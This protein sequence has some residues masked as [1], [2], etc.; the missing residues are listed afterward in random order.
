M[1]FGS[2]VSI[3]G[4]IDKA[5]ERAHSLGCECFQIFSRSPRGGKPPELTKELVDSFLSSRSKY[6]LTDYYIHTPYYINFA[7]AKKELRESASRIIREEL[8]RASI[9]G[10][11]YIMTHLGSSKDV[12]RKEA[13][14]MV[15]DGISK[16]IDGSELSS[17]LLLENTAG[18]GATIG[19]NFE[20]LAEILELVGD[21]DIGICIDTAHL[22][23]SGYDIRD[24]KALKQT[25]NI[26]SKTTGLNRVK[27]IHGNDSKADIGERK[28]RHEHIGKG[29]IGIDGFKAVLSSPELQNLNMIAELPPDKVASDITLLK[30]LREELT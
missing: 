28:D 14:R 29:K 10:A 9:I 17:L 1:K 15:A 5:P 21:P 23:A 16:A 2:H 22:L 18:Q 27:L 30:Q 4:G 3:A 24:S 13:V 7:S 6:S 8:E 12:S 25:L 11:G 26:I 20:E 19:D